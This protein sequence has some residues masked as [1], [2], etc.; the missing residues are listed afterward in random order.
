MRKIALWQFFT[1]N[2]VWLK[3]HIINFIT[4]NK[5]KIAYDPFAWGWD[6]LNVAKELW[7]INVEWMDIDKSLNWKYNDSLINIPYVKNSFIITN[8]PYLGKSSAKRKSIENIEF[9]FSKY[10][11]DDFYKIGVENI[12][13]WTEC[14]L[15][16]IPET[17]IQSSLIKD[18]EIRSR[19]T[20]ITIIEDNPFEDTDC[21]I[22]IVCFNNIKKIDKDILI[23]INDKFIFTL[24]ELEWKRLQPKNNINI[25]F[26]DIS[27]EI[28][29]IWVD[30]IDD[31]KRIRFLK[32]WELN[33]DLNKIKVSSRAISIINI[34]SFK[35]PINDLILQ[36]NK[37]LENYRT[38]TKDLLMSPFKWNTKSWKRRRRIDFKTVRALIEN[39]INN[40]KYGLWIH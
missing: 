34:E 18:K 32:K 16:I 14:G 15:I 38:E 19:I 12:F 5:S 4:E 13:K 28:A 24:D 3:D 2:K 10:K 7:F 40:K 6:L 17:F 26:N 30:M 11:H 36:L 20:S 21:P 35:M 8:P 29:L 31:I 1:K 33:Y 37:N 27:G 25:K 22:C 9:Y 39:T 23:Y